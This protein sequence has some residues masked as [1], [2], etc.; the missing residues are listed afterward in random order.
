MTTILLFISGVI[1]I[2]GFDFVWIGLLFNSFYKN[3]L[4]PF[5]QN[6]SGSWNFNVPAFF[7]VYGL[8]VGG[9]MVFVLPKVSI[10][11]GFK[12]AFVYGALFGAI[13]VGVYNLTNYSLL[14]GW[15]LAFVIKDTLW[16]MLNVGMTS[17][18]LYVLRNLFIK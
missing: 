6:V 7:I 16:A 15:S 18:F 10:T 4:R 11:G 13:A 5:S 3:A 1:A 9:I 8:I 14:S 12:Q 2:A 17:A